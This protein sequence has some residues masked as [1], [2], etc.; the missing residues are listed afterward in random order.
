M[1][2]GH[3]APLSAAIFNDAFNYVVSADDASEVFVWDVATGE[4][5]TKVGRCKLDPG[6]KA[7]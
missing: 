1:Y 3:K 7:T 4:R 2:T 6:L 5:E